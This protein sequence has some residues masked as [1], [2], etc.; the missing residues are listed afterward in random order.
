MGLES[1]GRL[2]LM[3]NVNAGLLRGTSK[4]AL[5]LLE[6]KNIYSSNF[7]YKIL[8]VMFVCVLGGGGLLAR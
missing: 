4:C 8:S 1:F 3:V 7:G 5:R 2:P 6:L